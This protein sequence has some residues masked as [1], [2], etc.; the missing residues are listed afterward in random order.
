MI[1][2]V[3]KRQQTDVEKEWG[4]HISGMSRN[5]IFVFLVRY[6]DSFMENSINNSRVDW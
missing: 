5:G 4:S 2:G 3:D 6:E 1:G